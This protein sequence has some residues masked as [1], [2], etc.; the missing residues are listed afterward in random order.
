MVHLGAEEEVEMCVAATE[1]E[2]EGVKV[3]PEEIKQGVQPGVQIMVEEWLVLEELLT[4]PEDH[5]GELL[6]SLEVQLGEY[7]AEVLQT[8]GV[9]LQEE[10]WIGEVEVLLLKVQLTGCL[11][12]EVVLQKEMLEAAVSSQQEKLRIAH[13]PLLLQQT[14]FQRLQ[15][16]II[17]VIPC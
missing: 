4:P 13:R 15:T 2:V 7:L 17:K 14:Q 11:M 16:Q 10:Q 3:H 6:V 8:E 1:V 5:P 12:R 9:L